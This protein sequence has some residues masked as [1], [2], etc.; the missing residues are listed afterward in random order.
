MR[1]GVVIGVGVGVVIFVE[2]IEGGRSEMGL[3]I[4]NDFEEMKMKDEMKEEMTSEMF[5]HFGFFEIERE[6]GAFELRGVIDE[7]GETDMNKF[8]DIDIING[9]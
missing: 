4:F 9:D 8:V 1:V 3:I 5:E 6:S 7:D 2:E